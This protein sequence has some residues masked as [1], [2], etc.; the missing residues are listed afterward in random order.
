MK[1]ITKRQLSEA[2]IQAVMHTA[3]GVSGEI[4]SVT[5]F[6]DGWFAAVYGVTL[7]DGR[8][9]VLKVSPDPA[10]RLLRYEVDLSHAETEFYRRATQ[11]GIPVPTV[12]YADP[13][14]GY[15]VVDRLRGRSLNTVRPEMT[16]GQLLALRRDIGAALARLHTVTGQRFGYLRRDGRTQS[17]SWRTSFLAMV[18]DIV[19]DAVEFDR[20]L[21]ADAGSIAGLIRRNA[22]VLDEVLV[23]VLLH[24]DLWDG[25]IFVRRE[26][27]GYVIDGFIDG[28]RAFY[29]DPIAELV[30]LTG[31]D[32][33]EQRERILA[34]YWGT[35]R[36][37]TENERLRHRLYSVYLDLIMLTEGAVRGFDPAEHAAVHDQV[38]AR[39][40]AS[41]EEL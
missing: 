39:L 36:P 18:D 17:A 1:S 41:L 24:F 35:A 29:G 11:A 7:A 16:G 26:G 10:L 2:S 30:C 5:E 13:D 32:D 19:A 14:G 34:G 12:R 15:L 21:P 27:E 38:F 25:N 9:L 20:K 33:P 22:S 23:P 37:L 8:E 40:S 6:T 31:A 4:G 3:F 28:E